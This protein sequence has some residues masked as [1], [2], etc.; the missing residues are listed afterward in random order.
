MQEERAIMP[1]DQRGTCRCL[2]LES[3]LL[4][5]AQRGHKTLTVLEQGQAEGP[6]PLTKAEDALIIGN[7]R[8]LKR[9][10]GFALDLQGGADAGNRSN[11]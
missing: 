3:C 7:R 9:G 4:V 10:V 5:V 2:V 8:G 1:L 11:G 6:I